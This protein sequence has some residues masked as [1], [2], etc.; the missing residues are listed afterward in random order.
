VA[1]FPKSRHGLPLYLAGAADL[2]GMERKMQFAYSQQPLDNRRAGDW[3]SL[4][5][6][7]LTATL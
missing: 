5:S 3:E 7:A 6:S 4:Q 1:P 2:E